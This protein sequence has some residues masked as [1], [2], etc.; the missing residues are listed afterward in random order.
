MKPGFDHG[1]AFVAVAALAERDP[2]TD[3]AFAGLDAVAQPGRVN[4]SGRPAR[5]ESLP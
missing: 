2:T 1:C 3:R 4:R 5:L